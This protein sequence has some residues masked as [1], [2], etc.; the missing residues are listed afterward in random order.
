MVATPKA[1]RSLTPQDRVACLYRIE[2]KRVLM[3]CLK[4]L[5]E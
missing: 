1:V 2:K 5:A 4:A 3:A